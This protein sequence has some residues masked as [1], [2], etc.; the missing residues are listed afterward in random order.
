MLKVS[1][2]KKDLLKIPS[3]TNTPGL[4]TMA[5]FEQVDDATKQLNKMADLLW[6]WRQ[7]LVDRLGSKLVTEVTDNSADDYENDA[8]RQEE[9]DVLH[10]A[11]E[12]LL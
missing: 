3:G 8:V 5:L 1:D 12:M 9:I 6:D 4:R 2:M 7:Q 10:D 11:Y